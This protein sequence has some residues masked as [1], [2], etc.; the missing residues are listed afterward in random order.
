MTIKNIFSKIINYNFTYK[1][2]KEIP[3]LIKAG[4]NTNIDNVHL[5]IRQMEDQKIYIEVGNDSL[6]NGN[7]NF[8]KQTGKVVIGDRTFIGG[9]SFICI[10]SITIGNDVMISWGGTF[11]D[12]NSHSLIWEERKNDVRDWKRGIDE[13]QI[14]KYKNW[15]VVESKPVTI[16]DK[17]WIGF[18][19][20]ILKGVTIG[21]GAIVAAGSVV[22]KDVPDYTVVGGNPAKIIKQTS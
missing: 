4:I 20:I 15:N 7:F 18:N 3:S 6:V 8:E 21:E 5:D 13:H 16:K 12:N 1:H 10:D 9:G 17:A 11:V 2:K 14:G 22:T 19:V